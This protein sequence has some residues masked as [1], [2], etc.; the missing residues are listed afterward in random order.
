M[1]NKQ[2]LHSFVK[3]LHWRKGDLGV[4]SAFYLFFFY[5]FHF[6]VHELCDNFCHR[7]ISC[8]KGKMP[9]DLVIDDREGGSTT[10]K[11]S[12]DPT[13]PSDPVVDQVRPISSY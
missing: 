5:F 8:L 11:S 12:S 6:Q 4:I 3:Y 1:S 10:S 7:Y 13:D 9:I 2:Y